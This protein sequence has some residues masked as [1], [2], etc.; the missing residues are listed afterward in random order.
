MSVSRRE[1]LAGAVATGA[2]AAATGIGSSWAG[3]APAWR[4]HH[5]PRLPEPNH[6]GLDHIVVLLM[7][8][9]SFDHFLGW[10]PGRAGEQHGLRY[11]DDAGVLHPTHH[12]HEWQGCG[13]NDP[14]HSYTGGRVQL[15]NGLLDGFRRGRN[16]DFALG[17]YKRRDLATMSQLVR[18]FTVCDRWFASILGPTFPNR[19][20]TH[21]A[22][23]DRISNT[24]DLV[25][26][27]TIWDRLAAAGVS[28]NYYYSDLPIL[29]LYGGKYDPIQKKIDTFFT[30]AAAGT[31]PS[32]SYVDPLFIGEAEGSSNDDHPHADIRRGQNLIGRVVQ[33]L[34]ESPQWKQHRADRHL[35]RVGRLLRPRPAAALPRRRR[36]SWRRRRR[37]RTTHRPVS[38]SRRSSSRRSRRRAA[39]RTRRSS[40]PRSSSSS[41][42]ASA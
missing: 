28:A 34:T 9:R 39:S 41:S 31:L 35:R 17:Y 6:S 22:S 10:V 23:T 26:L 15:D 8:N 13:F 16:D 32:Y 36:P 38:V 5:K 18:H 40:T 4:P 19:L 2:V 3:A 14:D 42:G 21:S 11:P 25:S 20:Y 24:F 37:T 29:A 1:L 7:E 12:L 33:A 27:P 30:D